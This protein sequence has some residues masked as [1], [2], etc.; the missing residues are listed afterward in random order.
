MTTKKK[1]KKNK[2][3]EEKTVEMQEPYESVIGEVPKEVIEKAEESTGEEQSS[4]PFGEENKQ[5][6]EK[7]TAR[8]RKLVE[9]MLEQLSIYSIVKLVKAVP[10]YRELVYD[11]IRETRGDE[12][13]EEYKSI[14]EVLW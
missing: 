9:V 3:N 6:T 4:E 11:V 14:E 2:D 7:Y 1:D 10:E 8:E 12:G 13:L 5:S